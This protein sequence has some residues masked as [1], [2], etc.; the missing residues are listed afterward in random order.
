MYL[1]VCLYA[2]TNETACRKDSGCQ[3]HNK[4]MPRFH[5]VLLS[6]RLNLFFSTLDDS[7]LQFAIVMIVTVCHCKYF[8][9]IA[10]AVY[11]F[12]Y[13]NKYV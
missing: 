6:L 8:I 5:H 9:S 3:S 1:P 4:E 11:V 2:V 7:K 12:L 10:P 13:D